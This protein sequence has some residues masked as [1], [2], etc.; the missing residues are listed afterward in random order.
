MYDQ[1]FRL[2]D[3][4]TDHEYLPQ[5]DAFAPGDILFI[6]Y[7]DKDWAEAQRKATGSYYDHTELYIGRGAVLQA[8]WEGVHL[9]PLI[10]KDGKKARRG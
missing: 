1:H 8:T 6:R 2:L 9:K 10:V 7:C 4:Y 5:I 3:Y